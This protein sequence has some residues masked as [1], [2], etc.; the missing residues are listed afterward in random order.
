[1]SSGGQ[2]EENAEVEVDSAEGAT[3][4]INYVSFHSP[5]LRPSLHLEE[6]LQK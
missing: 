5:T 4:N 1:M 3:L 6:C 2:E